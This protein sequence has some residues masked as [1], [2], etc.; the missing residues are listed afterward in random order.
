M[1][2]AIRAFGVLFIREFRVRD[3]ITRHRIDR[4]MHRT[5]RQQLQ[6]K[7]VLDV[8]HVD[9]GGAETDKACRR[10]R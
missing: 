1:Q 8:K 10:L 9:R 2:H 6:A 7:R 4:D 5:N 3:A